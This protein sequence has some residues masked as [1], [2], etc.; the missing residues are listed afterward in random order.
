MAE[1]KL[2]KKNI[3]SKFT[4]LA[5][6]ICL[7]SILRQWLLRQVK[8]LVS[9]STLIGPFALSHSSRTL[10]TRP[11]TRVNQARA[12][13]GYFP[14]P[15][16]CATSFPPVEGQVIEW[17]SANGPIRIE[18]ESRYLTLRSGHWHK[19]SHKHIRKDEELNF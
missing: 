13:K 10:T 18:D 4:S 5:C 11:S 8:Y 14:T 19:V 17:L 2:M 16:L 9:S 12:S 7:W 1:R 3:S 15:V 6:L